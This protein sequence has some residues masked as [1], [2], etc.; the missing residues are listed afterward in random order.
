M[1]KIIIKTFFFCL[2]LMTFLLLP[3]KSQASDLAFNLKGKFLIQVENKGMIWYINPNTTLRHKISN[4]FEAFNFLKE[5]GL[6]ISN[7]NLAKIP[8]AVDKRLVKIDS[9][10]DGLDDELERAIGTD[11]YNPD[12][13]GDG[14]PDGLEVLNHFDPLGPGRLPIDLNFSASLAGQILLQVEN[15]GEAW[16]VNPN[17]NLRYYIHSP[18]ELFKV[19][20]LIGQGITNNDIEKIVDHSLIPSN[21]LKNIKLD[22]GLNQRL[23]YFLDDILIGS[24]P[25]SAG[26]ASTPTP[27][28]NYHII[29]KHPQAWSPLGLWM[30]YWLGLGTGRF[31]I[32]ELPFWPNGYREGQ[33]HLGIPVSN[34]CVRLGIGPAKFIYNWSKVGT[35]VE[36]Y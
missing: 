19:A 15:N 26:K 22:V 20:S 13:D 4:E 30:P 12:T 31:G 17:D 23:Y 35:P 9:D 34:G 14:Y 8:I 28:G 11:P 33:N 10:G 16:Y 24:F 29:N 18:Q 2:F 25:I 6:G 36:I 3:F 1:N 7:I 21:A 5:F 32:H 27:K